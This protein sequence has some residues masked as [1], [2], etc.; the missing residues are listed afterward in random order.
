MKNILF[1]YLFFASVI[2][3]A[4][5]NSA[6]L[7]RVENLLSKRNTYLAKKEIDKIP[8][9]SIFTVRYWKLYSTI[10]ARNFMHSKAFACLDSALVLEPKNGEI[11]L[12]IAVLNMDLYSDPAKALTAINKGILLEKDPEFYFYRGIY[13]QMLEKTDEAIADYKFVFDSGHKENGLLRNYALVLQKK[14]MYALA[15]SIISLEIINQPNLPVLYMIK[16][17][18]AMGLLN[19]DSVVTHYQKS[20]SLNYHGDRLEM[21]KAVIN[22]RN[23]YT[24]GNILIAMKDIS[25]AKE[26]FLKS[27]DKKEKY[28]DAYFHIGYCASSLKEYQLSEKYYNLAEKNGC[29]SKSL[30]YNN[31]ALLYEEMGKHE[32]E[33]EMLNLQIK[34]SPTDP[35]PYIHR[36]RAYLTLK[37]YEKSEIDYNHALKIQPNYHRAFGYL[38]HLQ[39]EMGRYQ[40]ALNNALLAIESK[41]DYGF[42]YVKLGNAKVALE[43]SGYCEDFRNAMKY[44]AKEGLKFYNYYCIQK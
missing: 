39:L 9:N 15:D 38:A 4:Q 26:Y 28:I 10:H 31:F 18:I 21:M 27:I 1:T 23:Y 42:G 3:N 17:D 25:L 30:L 34:H 35:N 36:G 14:K 8:T 20:I 7:D 24:I 29:E 16:G 41:P 37:M 13:N 44:N 5:N 22:V 33:I 6:I 32:K 2:L 19:I 11:Y 40:E 12:E 43:M